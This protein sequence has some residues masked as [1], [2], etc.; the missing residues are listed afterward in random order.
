MLQYKNESNSIQYVDHI[1][2]QNN[3]ELKRSG[4]KITYTNIYNEYGDR[5]NYE[6][7]FTP[8]T[9]KLSVNLL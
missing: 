4:Q 8:K 3:I 2:F 6:S 7:I 9:R 5:Q 1:N